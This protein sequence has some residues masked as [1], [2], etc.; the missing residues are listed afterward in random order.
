MVFIASA[1]RADLGGFSQRI[2][3]ITQNLSTSEINTAA[4]NSRIR[5]TDV[6]VASAKKVKAKIMK[7]ASLKL[8]NIAN[9]N[10]AHMLKLIS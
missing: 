9:N 2:N 3:Y 10:S 8:L 4:S 5:D 7:D 1:K 6:A